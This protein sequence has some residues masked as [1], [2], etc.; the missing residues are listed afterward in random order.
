[1]KTYAYI[2][3]VL[4]AAMVSTYTFASGADSSAYQGALFNGD[5][6]K[7]Y[8]A[9]HSGGPR[10]IS[11][12]ASVQQQKRGLEY[13]SGMA[14]S[15]LE[16]NHM[17]A[18]LGLDVTQWLTV[19]GGVGGADVTLGNQNLGSDN[20]DYNAEW[21]VGGQVRMMDFMV[22]EPWN[23]I[24]QYWV[25]L[26][27]NSYF[28][29]TTVDSRGASDNLSEIFTSLTMSFY[30]KPEKPGAWDR[31]GFYIGPAFSSLDFGD[32]SESQ[33][34]GL[35]GGLQINPSANIGIKLE[36][37]EFDK[38]GMGASVAFHF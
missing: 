29:N 38:L 8:D 25:G 5:S 32:Q 4:A 17:A 20:S 7:F 13:S 9:V 2:L 6:T 27:L 3:T 16:V 11:V 22:L 12:G 30:S 23:D 34:F 21:Q 36:L 15:E 33:L 1:M 28:R 37:Q 26:D 18:I 14:G 31:I 35:I 19:Y 10:L 24:D